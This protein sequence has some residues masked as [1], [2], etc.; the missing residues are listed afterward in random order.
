MSKAFK[1]PLIPTQQQQVLAELEADSRLVYHC[2]LTPQKV[3]ARL[4]RNRS[5]SRNRNKPQQ[6]QRNPSAPKFSSNSKTTPT[7]P[8]TKIDDNPQAINLQPQLWQM[9][10]LTL[11]V[12]S[13]HN[14]CA[15]AGPGGEQSHDRHRVLAEAH[16]VVAAKRVPLGPRKHGHVPSLHGSR[17]SVSRAQHG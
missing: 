11:T 15:A 8:E 16:V 10:S 12:P 4:R 14:S 5:C 9:P 13:P 7:T 1:G 3:S 17:E 6:R 2:G